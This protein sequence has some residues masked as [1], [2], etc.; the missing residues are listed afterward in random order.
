MS[1]PIKDLIILVPDNNTQAALEGLFSRPEALGIR[2]VEFDIFRHPQHDPGCYL[3]GVAFLSSLAESYRHALLIFDFEGSGAE[4]RSADEIEE[5]LGRSLE[6]SEWGVRASVIVIRPELE[7][8]VWSDS[9]HVETGL[10]WTDPSLSLRQ[11]LAS[12]NY[13]RENDVKPARP[14]EAM[15]A[16]LRKSKKPRSS[17]IYKYLAKIGRASCRERV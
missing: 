15:E 2:S 1:A 11:W 10:G 5:E 8:W 12:K 13:L 17:S 14:K 3:S 6:L 7:N 9:P 4:G 16:A